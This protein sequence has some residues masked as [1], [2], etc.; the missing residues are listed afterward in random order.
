M[1]DIEPMLDGTLPHANAL[2]IL[3]YEPHGCRQVDTEEEEEGQQ[4]GGEKTGQTGSEPASRPPSRPDRLTPIDNRKAMQ[5][6][7]LVPGRLTDL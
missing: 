4:E 2:C 7:V 5:N 3:R 1:C 6:A